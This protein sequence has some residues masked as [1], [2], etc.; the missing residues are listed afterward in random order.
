MDNTIAMQLY[1]LLIFTISGIVIG[2]LFDI[3]R[4]LRKSFKTSD[5]LTYIEDIL[6][7]ILTGIFLLFVI[8]KFN[9]GQIRSYVVI[10]LI[11]GIVIYILTIS[12]YFIMINVKIITFIKK[13]I[14]YPINLFIKIFKK[15]LKPFSFIVINV[16]KI[17]K[18]FINKLKI[19]SKYI[20]NST[21][22]AKKHKKTLRKEGF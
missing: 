14:I 20:L 1:S 19:K 16:R 21:K 5:F 10:G 9:N 6:F 18:D 8:F 2:I 7:W 15:L 22:I 3:F 11:L 12:K 4:V 17:I 13:I